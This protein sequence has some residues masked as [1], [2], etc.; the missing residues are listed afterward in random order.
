[1]RLADYL[2]T[3]KQPEVDSLKQNCGL[4]K[5]ECEMLDMVKEKRSYAEI[6]QKMGYSTATVGRRIQELSDR[7]FSADKK[8]IPI[9]EKL[10]L[11]IEEAA[12]YSNIGIN[13]INDM[14]KEPSCPFVLYIGKGKRVIKRRE[15]EKYLEKKREV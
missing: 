3:L 1:M 5:E 13:K 11:S 6:A 2:R 8:S 9:W 7:V 14:L 10:N 12:A 15:F 4:T